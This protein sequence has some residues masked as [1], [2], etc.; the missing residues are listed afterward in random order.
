[1]GNISV[2]YNRRDYRRNIRAGASGKKID[3][4]NDALVYLFLADKIGVK[5]INRMDRFNWVTITIRSHISFLVKCVD[6]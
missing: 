6:G 3:T 1:M 2:R 4:A 5:R